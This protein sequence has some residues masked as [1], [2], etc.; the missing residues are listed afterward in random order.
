VFA[1]YGRYYARVAND[2]AA[3][4]LPSDAVISA[5]YFDS[6]LTGPVPNG[7]VTSTTTGTTTTTHFCAEGDAIRRPAGIT[8]EWH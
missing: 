2:L 5:D 8:S 4:A 7:V 1:N 3:R 6:N